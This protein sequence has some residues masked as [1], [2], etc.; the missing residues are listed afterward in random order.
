MNT[1]CRNEGAR[2]SQHT[3]LVAQK[4]T[5][6]LDVHRQEAVCLMPVFFRQGCR[7]EGRWEEEKER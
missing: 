2:N 3:N 1:R 5:R 7:R 4:H 6:R